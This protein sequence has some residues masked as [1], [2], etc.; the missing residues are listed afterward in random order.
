MR[1]APLVELRLVHPYYADGRCPDLEVTLS[2]AG[3]RVAAR[4][5]L[6]ARTRP[7]RLLL[8]A[9][10]DA[11]GRARVPLDVD[12]PIGLELRLRNPDFVRFTD[13]G[14]FAAL[15]APLLGDGGAVVGE[16]R[17][18]ERPSPTAAEERRTEGTR[19]PERHRLGGRPAPW[20]SASDLVI[21]GPPALGVLGYDADTR[22]VDLDVLGVAPGS[23]FTISYPRAATRP[24]GVFAEIE[25]RGAS[26]A[27]LAE[28]PAIYTLTF[29]P[30]ALRWVYYL[31]TDV[32][33][34]A[35][36]LVDVSGGD[37]PLRFAG[38]DRRDLGADPDPS[39]RQ[40]AGLAAAYP[41]KRR[42]RFVSA[43]AVPCSER[44]SA[45]L[46][47]HLDGERLPQTLSLPSL[48]HLTHLEV[49]EGESVQ[50]RESLFHV[51]KHMTSSLPTNG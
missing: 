13:L 10:V 3:A 24:P 25:L 7:D 15:R 49:L 22:E 40:A 46:E 36:D 37:A 17:L 47:L 11:E 38:A 29:T 44:P 43:S 23:P 9:E 8:L 6:I 30:R 35:F 27:W 20:A 4:G 32:E 26:A 12:T 21:E 14:A 5:R 1:Y 33:S 45:R 16:L 39:D 18:G 2:E 41:D 50:R 51:V 28:S 19:T 42:L 31:V 48:T 34:G